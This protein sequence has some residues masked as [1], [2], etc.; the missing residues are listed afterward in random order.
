M[1]TYEMIMCLR[2]IAIFCKG[3]LQN[4]IIYYGTSPLEV[5]KKNKLLL[6]LVPLLS[7]Y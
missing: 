7:E 2:D 5:S 6:T 3:Y 1:E 4:V